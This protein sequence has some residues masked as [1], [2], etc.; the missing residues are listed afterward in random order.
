MGVCISV[1][2]GVC[3]GV[4]M[5]ICMDVY[6]C[7]GVYMRCM[8]GRVCMGCVHNRVSHEYVCVSF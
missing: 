4:Y 6:A 7:V 3:I 5:G 1:Y 8:Y 2:M